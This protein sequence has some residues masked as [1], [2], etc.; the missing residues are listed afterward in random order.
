LT[1]YQ[2]DGGSHL[3]SITYLPPKP[4][5]TYQIRNLVSGEILFKAHNGVLTIQNN[6]RDNSAMILIFEKTSA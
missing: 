6:L 1:I 3:P 5:A 2:L 4:E